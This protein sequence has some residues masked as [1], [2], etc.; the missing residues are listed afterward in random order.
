MSHPKVYVTTNEAPQSAISIMKSVAEVRV[1]KGAAAPPRSVLL[2]EVADVDGLFCLLTERVDSELLERAKKLKV[3]GNMAVGHD[4]VDLDEA[5]KRGVLV[6][7]TPGILTE[8]V[9]D[10][11]FALILATARRIV[12][13]NRYLME[14][15]WRIRW[16]P[17]MMAGTD[18]HGKVLGIYGLGRIGAA[19]ARRAKG[20]GMDVMYFGTTRNRKIERECGLTFAPLRELL[21]KCD[22]LSIHVPLLPETRHAIGRKELSLMKKTAFIINTARGPVIDEGALIEALRT[23]KIAGAGLDVFE[24]EPIEPKNPLLKLDNVVLL[25]HI[26]SASLETRTAMAEMAARNIVAGLKG[27]IP[28][29]LLNR[30]ALPA[31]RASLG[32]P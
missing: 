24:N 7:N 12:E 16:S 14:K 30:E 10:A 9:A 8:T 5:S 19:V 23:G 18:V 13:A 17:M 22:V 6:T 4:N 32:F 1:Y 25:P 26:G 11:T 15:R 20:F 28:P 29:Q 21:H 3:V 31:A 27:E 2:R